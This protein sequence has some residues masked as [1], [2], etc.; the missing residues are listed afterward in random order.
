MNQTFYFTNTNIR[1]EIKRN[2]DTWN[3]CIEDILYIKYLILACNG[4]T[5]KKEEAENYFSRIRSPSVSPFIESI[6]G[7][8]DNIKG[9]VFT[10]EKKKDF[11]LVSRDECRKWFNPSF[12]KNKQ[13]IRGEVHPELFRPLLTKQHCLVLN[14]YNEIETR[15]IRKISYHNIFNLCLPKELL[16]GQEGAKSI[17]LKFLDWP[18]NFW[19]HLF[20]S[21]N[22]KKLDLRTVN[23]LIALYSEVIRT[24]ATTNSKDNS[25]NITRDDNLWADLDILINEIQNFQLVDGYFD[26]T[27]DD[28]Y[29]AMSKLLSGS[30]KFYYHTVIE[31]KQPL[32]NFKFNTVNEALRWAFTSF[33]PK[34]FHEIRTIAFNFLEDKIGIDINLSSTGSIFTK[35]DN[36]IDLLI[37]IFDGIINHSD[38][39]NY[40][41][42][43]TKLADLLTVIESL[44][45]E[46]IQDEEQIETDDPFKVLRKKQD[47][48]LKTFSMCML[49]E[50]F[51]S[52]KIKVIDDNGDILKRDTYNL[53]DL[54]LYVSI[55]NLRNGFNGKDNEE[56]KKLFESCGLLSVD[57]HEIFFKNRYISHYLVEEYINEESFKKEFLENAYTHNFILPKDFKKFPKTCRALKHNKS[58]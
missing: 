25:K 9:G 41:K 34:H 18:R 19:V 35:P 8:V 48:L 42:K 50:L 47:T 11:D 49:T 38:K 1:K 44:D 52:D 3:N 10:E 16:I 12:M 6:N 55:K 53:Y 17:N 14:S 45:D 43:L 51:Y 54:L 32:L 36:K 46:K 20:P 4:K 27:D 28:V 29:F 31:I 30:P 39:K 2:I 23:N 15:T 13:Y 24:N 22:I 7:N 57:N 58:H 26:L 21:F 40:Y 33:E 56:G 37:K 5:I